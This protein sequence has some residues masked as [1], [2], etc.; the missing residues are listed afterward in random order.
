[1]VIDSWDPA[2][3]MEMAHLIKERH[4]ATPYGFRFY[5]RSRNDDELDSRVTN[6]SVFYWLGGKVET[7]EE[8]EKRND[9]SEKILRINMRCNNYKKIITNDNSWRHTQALGEDDI[10]LDWTPRKEAQNVD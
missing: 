1:M 10:I 3:A 6:T 5:E 2:K 4:G 7:L 8:V 9:P